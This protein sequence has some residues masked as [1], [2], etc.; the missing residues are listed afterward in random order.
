MKDENDERCD[1]TEAQLLASLIASAQNQLIVNKQSYRVFGIII[2]GHTFK[3][4]EANVKRSYLEDLANGQK[5]KDQV[6]VIQLSNSGK[7]SFS[8]LDP[9]DRQII[10]HFCE[11]FCTVC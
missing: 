6:E 2:I 5:P 9:T 7:I 3:F 10:I 4:Y 11:L 8:Y 1:D